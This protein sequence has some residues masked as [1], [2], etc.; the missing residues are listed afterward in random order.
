MDLIR[1]A[2]STH[3]NISENSA[4]SGGAWPLC[5]WCQRGRVTW[6]GC[7]HQVQRGRLLAFWC[8]CCTWW[9]PTCSRI[10]HLYMVTRWIY[11]RDI[12]CDRMHDSSVYKQKC[13]T[14]S[15]N[16]LR[17]QLTQMKDHSIARKQQII[18][19]QSSQNE[20]REVYTG[21]PLSKMCIHAG[22]QYTSHVYVHTHFHK[23]KGMYMLEN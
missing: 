12:R 6:C 10:T 2:Q 20:E 7:C 22:S 21:S 14:T 8:M 18:I 19:D 11:R 13:R 4:Y 9:Q 16:Q 23:R 17:K 1:G 15:R 3:F 5:P